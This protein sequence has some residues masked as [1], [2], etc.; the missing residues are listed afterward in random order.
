[1]KARRLCFGSALAWR[2]EGRKTLPSV[3]RGNRKGKRVGGRSPPGSGRKGKREG[4]KPGK[5]EAIP[6]IS[7]VWDRFPGNL[8]DLLTEVR[9]ENALRRMRF[10]PT[11]ALLPIEGELKPAFSPEFL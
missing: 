3:G 11:M 4:A 8:L 7:G 9:G 10:T 5:C 6:P 2:P 1:M